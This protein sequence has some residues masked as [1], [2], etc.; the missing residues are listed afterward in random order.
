MDP[1]FF[2]DPDLDFKNPDLDPYINKLMGSKWR[3]WLGFGWTWPKR[4]VLRVLKKIYLFF[5]FLTF[6]SCIR[7]RIFRIR[8]G[9]SV[10]G[11]RF[12]AGFRKKVR[13][14][15]GKK[16][17]IRNTAF[18]IQSPTRFGAG[19]S[20]L[21]SSVWWKLRPCSRWHWKEGYS[22][23]Q[24]TKFLFQRPKMKTFRLAGI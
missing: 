23:M 18:N 19:V 6:L 7:I 21:I 24:E 2:A 20:T 10:S 15:S 5:S 11:S 14:G 3:F 1:G 8:S 16:V 4:T 13:S 9:F 17:L 12:L 22:W